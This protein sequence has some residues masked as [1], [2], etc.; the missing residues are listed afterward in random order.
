M[1][2]HGVLGHGRRQQVYHQCAYTTSEEAMAV[3]DIYIILYIIYWVSY[4]PHL[5]RISPHAQEVIPPLL[6]TTNFLPPQARHIHDTQALDAAPARLLAKPTP[7]LWL[8]HIF[9]PLMRSLGHNSQYI[10][11][12]DICNHPARPRPRNRAENQPSTRLDVG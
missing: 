5:L 11:R 10:L 12:H 4:C 9:T 8:V 7:Q 3:S 6:A 1:A 2:L